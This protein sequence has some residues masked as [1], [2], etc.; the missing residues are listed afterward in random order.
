M[1]IWISTSRMW[2]KL[3]PQVAEALS[4]AGLTLDSNGSFVSNSQED[5]AKVDL[6]FALLKSI[7]FRRINPQNTGLDDFYYVKGNTTVRM[8][9][10]NEQGH[11][12]IYSITS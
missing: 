4:R 2:D 3:D 11:R 7:K 12:T 10:R 9:L 6:F 1:K 5:D 8:T